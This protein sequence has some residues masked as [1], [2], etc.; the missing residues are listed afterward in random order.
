[1]KRDSGSVRY[2][3]SKKWKGDGRMSSEY[4]QAQYLDGSDVYT[5]LESKLYMQLEDIVYHSLM[6]EVYTTPK[7]GLVDR[8][9]NGAH[10]DMNVNTFAESAE[11]IAP[12]IVKMFYCGYQRSE[13]EQSV[14]Q[15]IR[16][17]G[18][19]AE[20]EM[21]EATDGVNTH[22]GLIFTMGILAAAAGISVRKYASVEIEEV[23]AICQRMTRDILQKEFD[24]IKHRTPSSHG[25]YLY[26]TYGEK[27]IR[28][29]A[30]QGFPVL[31]EVAYPSLK[32]YR[33]RAYNQNLSNI[34]VLLQVMTRLNDTNILS[35][36]TKEDLDWIK[37]RA[38]EILQMDGVFTA[39]G[40]RAIQQFN[41]ECIEKNISPGGA[42][43]MLAAAIFLYEMEQL[44]ERSDT[45]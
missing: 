9:D 2:L 22:K 31:R 30:M 35:R 3:F 19:E 24:E 44:F 32:E 37:A 16:Q 14:F 42:A 38:A 20:S 40:Y 28:G 6:G 45:E 23:F 26:H 10:R 8:H 36:G 13:E 11:A 4:M 34:N 18:V 5:H 39:K 17:I 41:L 33:R 7:P 12:Y 29:E 21:F 15:R 27:G 1:M 25:E 43:D